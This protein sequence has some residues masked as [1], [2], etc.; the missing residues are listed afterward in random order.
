MKIKSLKI[1]VGSF[2][3]IFFMGC[4]EDLL[5]E[6]PPHI[7]SAESLYTSLAGYEAGLNGLYATLRN[8]RGRTR[9]IEMRAG[10]FFGG[11]DNLVS[12]HKSRSGFNFV[13]QHWGDANNPDEPFYSDVF[14]WLYSVINAANTIINRAENNTDVDWTGGDGTPDENKSRVIAEARTMRAWAY[15]HLTYGWG[16][17]PLSLEESYGSNIKTDWVRTPVEE[18]RKQII[19]DL[20][21]A[22]KQIPVQPSMKGRITKGAI[23]H[24]LSEMYLVFDKPDSALY[25]ADKV[26]NTPEYMLI[27][28][29]YGVNMDKEGVPIRDMFYEGNENRDQGNTEALWVWQFAVQTLGGSES[30]IRRYH[31][32]R[33][34]DWYI[35]VD[36]VRALKDT[37]E[38]GGR[39][40]ARQSMTKWAIDLYE[41]QDD[42]ASNH[43]IRKFYI[44]KDEVAQAPYPADVLPSGYAYGDTIWLNWDNDLSVTNNNIRNWP[45]CRK[46]EGTNPDDV[47]GSYQYNDVVYLRLAETYLLKA[48][49]EFLLGNSADAASTINIVRRRSNASDVS[50]GDID[51]DFILD[52]RS[53]EL[54][55]EEH[56]RWTLLRTGKLLERVALHNLNGGQLISDRDILFPIPQEVIDANIS[57]Q[58][59]QNP[60]W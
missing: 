14:T 58:M 57:V 2:M 6:D 53:R 27:T 15:R 4:S 29:R 39:G 19:A 60:G 50:A 5:K 16:D 3:L 23:Q 44:L 26:I 7:V 31:A 59:S 17:V 25:W 41:P 35:G 46:V 34:S 43:V 10:M 8:E 45:F 55:L 21:F 28:E 37:Y 47:S 52:E 11:T 1:F 42:R 51:I 32:T 20:L 18:V 56:R 30:V 38:R 13:S 12:N 49:A 24:Y 36:R 9:D 22:E 33:I 54:V 40:R 48:E